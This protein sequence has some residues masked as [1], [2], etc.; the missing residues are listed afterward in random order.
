MKKEKTRINQNTRDSMTRPPQ[1]ETINERKISHQLNDTY[2]VHNNNNNNQ[3]KSNEIMKL[4]KKNITDAL[5]LRR[6]RP[7]LVQY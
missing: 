4:P 3:I 5:C 7:C 2:F 1:P 6:C